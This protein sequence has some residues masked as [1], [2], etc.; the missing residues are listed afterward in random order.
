VQ[1]SC[2]QC[3][4]RIAIDD[5]KVP[6]RPFKVKCPKC[7]NSVTLP[8]KG[9]AAPAGVPGTLAPGA[10][11][12]PP[13]A[14]AAPSDELRSQLMADLRREMGMGA[15]G[16]AGRALVSLADRGA[17]GAVT[18]TLGRLGYQADNIEDPEEGARSLEQGLY[19]IVATSRAGAAGTR[20]ENLYQ[21]LTRLSPENR[22]RIFLVLVGDEYQTG[23]GL[24]AWTAAADLVLS[25]RDAATADAT[26]RNTLNERQRLYQV[27]LDAR[28]RFE[29]SAG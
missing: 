2:P 5:A 7:G 26:I 16:A 20:G 18:G 23:D 19:N 10:P 29:E 17:A 4:Q 1:A 21:R 14:P 11:A 6:D 3:S 15:P 24:Q 9:A 22:R 25:G 8:G 28:R 27:F 13:A 12:E